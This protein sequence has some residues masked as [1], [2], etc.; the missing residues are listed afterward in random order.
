MPIVKPT[1]NQV[2]SYANYGLEFQGNTYDPAFT[3]GWLQSAPNVSRQGTYCYLD[4]SQSFD[5]SDRTFLK[6]TFG[7][8]SVGDT[9]YI[10]PT[11]YYDPAT[12]TRL[13]MGGTCTFSNSLND[14]KII[15]GTVVS[16]LTYDSSYNFYKKENFVNPIQYTFSLTGS[17]TNNFL[18]NTF[19]QTAYTTIK[20]MGFLGDAL[21]FEEYIEVSGA[22]GNNYGRLSVQG[23]ITLK[24]NQEIL[25]LQSGITTQSLIS[26]SND[27]KMYIRGK[28]TVN[29]IQQPENVTGIYRIHDTNNKLVD[30]YENQNYYQVVLR[31][32]GLTSGYNGYWVE[33]PTCPENIYGQNLSID[34]VPPTL[35]YDNSVYLYISQLTTNSALTFTPTLNYGVF[36]QRTFT[37]TPQSASRL[38]F[39][40]NTGLKIDL[41]HASLQGWKFDVFTDFNYTIPL[42]NNIYISGEPGFDKSYVLITSTPSTPRSLYCRFTGLQTINMLFNI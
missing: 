17:T 25:Y 7:T 39:A 31:S 19:P 22:T 3:K 35:L 15:I 34:G 42:L 29:E 13:S 12:N 20:K 27:I 28:S 21:G 30:C 41:S 14:G 11:E 38:T 37:G 2:R 33:C 6:R 36:T 40:I 4:Y 26:S 24:D 10:Q 16:G 8:L 32:Q 23:T 18:V 1:L 5:T 9:F